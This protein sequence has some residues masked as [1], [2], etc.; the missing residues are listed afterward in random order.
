MKRPIPS[1]LLPS[2][3]VALALGCGSPPCQDGAECPGEGADPGGRDDGGSESDGGVSNDGGSSANDSG[4]SR[5][6]GPRPDGG[7]A[8][9]GGDSDGGGALDGGDSDGG[10]ALDGGDSDGGSADGGGS[11]DGGASDGGASDGGVSD[12]GVSDGGSDGGGVFPGGCISGA[13]GNYAARF[14]WA[15]NGP[16]S[17]AYVQYDLNNFPDAS[18]W[19]AGAYS[20]G[21]VGYQPVFTDTFLG[22][23][24]L[25]M[26]GTVFMDV[27]L[28]TARLS[29]IRKVSL[30]ILGRSFNTTAGGSF[31]WQSFDDTGATP[32]G[33]VSNVAP[34]R[35][36]VADATAAFRPGNAGVLLRISPGGPSGTLIVSRVEICIDGQ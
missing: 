12:G 13:T 24:G 8:L 36:Y 22:V 30:A 20:R 32:S 5:D 10:G 28:S 11:T 31:S 26:G 29:T 15:G 6:A 35:W 33:F 23:G 34:Y 9:D 3:F 16:S 18:R 2:L 17:R 19:K 25:E 4:S 27:E 7:G 21:A 1:L 14:R